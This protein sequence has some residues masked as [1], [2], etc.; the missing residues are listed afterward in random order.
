MSITTFDRNLVMD[1]PRRVV[2]AALADRTRIWWLQATAFVLCTAMAMSG[3]IKQAIP[4]ALPIDFTV[5]ITGLSL[6]AAVIY[7]VAARNWP[8]GRPLAVVVLLLVI[9]LAGSVHQSHTEQ[10]AE[11]ADRFYVLTLLAVFLTTLVVRHHRDANRLLWVM[12]GAALG[13]TGWIAFT[14]ESKYG[15]GSRIVSQLGS[16]IAFGRTAGFV[17]VLAIAWLLT[18]RRLTLPRLGVAA[19]VVSGTAWTMFA[20]ASRGPIQAVAVAA[21]AMV[22]PQLWRMRAT[23][24]WRAMVLIGSLVATVVAV[25]SAVPEGARERIVMVDGAS[26]DSRKFAWSLTWSN[27]DASLFGNG[28]GSF[29]ERTDVEGLLYP[30]MF[31]LE[32]WYEAGL[33]GL[34]ALLGLLWLAF[35]NQLRVFPVDPGAATLALGAATFWAA[36]AMVSGDVNDNKIM[37]VVFAVVAAAPLA[38][39]TGAAET[40]GSA[41][42]VEQLGL[43]GAEPLVKQRAGR[44]RGG[45]GHRVDPPVEAAAQP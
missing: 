15:E 21:V 34:V 32:V 12:G 37:W 28:W 41:G 18:T 23:G 42:A 9:A 36:S 24:T 5:L 33:V 19:A 17:I 44:G 40:G 10:A 6:G 26:S 20:I 43:D 7:L 45:R 25:W 11:K 30:H 27:L 35:S 13:L 22:A 14:G 16:T 1:P 29:A 8:S 38:A 31:L 3:Q 2:P 39:R 4:V